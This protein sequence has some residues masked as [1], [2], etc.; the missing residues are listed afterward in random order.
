MKSIKI[1]IDTEDAKLK[2]DTLIEKSEILKNNLNETSMK[3]LNDN[4]SWQDQPTEDGYYW[5]RENEELSIVEV[6]KFET[7][8]PIVFYNGNEC[9]EN[10]MD[11]TGKWYGPIKPPKE[12]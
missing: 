8:Y 4:L 7:H 2:L 10:L 11:I 12:D 6:L 9:E 5:L 1:N 3:L